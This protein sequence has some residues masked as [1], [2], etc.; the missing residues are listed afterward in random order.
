MIYLPYIYLYLRVRIGTDLTY[1]PEFGRVALE[2]GR[3]TL[4]ERMK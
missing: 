2:L 3:G 4:R 1:R